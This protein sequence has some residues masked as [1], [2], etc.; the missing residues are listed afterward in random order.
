MREMRKIKRKLS[1]EESYKLLNNV[2][3]ITISMYDEIE[4]VPYAVS[5]NAVVL[6][7]TIYIHCANE[8][9]KIDVLKR[10]SSVCITCICDSKILEKQYTT[11]Y[12]SLVI[13]SHARFIDKNEEKKLV[14]RKLCENLTP[15][16]SKISIEN[17]IISAIDKTTI[18]AFDVESIS[19]KGSYR[20]RLEK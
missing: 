1:D 18:I 6:G 17:V 12:E 7:H 11:A 10:N 8:G 5:I 14:L 16:N 4:K 20:E 15:I 19:G 2:N 3:T 9:R 13:F